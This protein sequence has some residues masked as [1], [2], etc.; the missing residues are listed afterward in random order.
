MKSY[1]ERREEQRRYESDVFYEVWRSGGNTDRIDPD[2]VQDRYYNGQD[3]E[4]A[5]SAELWAQRPKPQEPSEE[6]YYTE[7]Q[8]Q[9]AMDEQPE[10]PAE[11]PNDERIRGDADAR[12]QT[13]ALSPSDD[14]ACSE[15][16]PE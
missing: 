10:A 13:G 6:E 4:S 16:Q 2:R 1:E 14:A 11:P 12:K 8:R 5:A 3:A 7:M 9:Q 15:N